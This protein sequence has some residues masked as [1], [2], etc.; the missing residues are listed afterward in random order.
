MSWKDNL[1]IV[2]VEPR[3]P[4]NIGAAARAM[5]NFGFTRLALVAP[6]EVAF[7]EARSAVGAAAVL[8]DACVA[9]SL[10]AAIADCSLVVG[11]A[12]PEG[13]VFRQPRRRL[14]E[15]ARRLRAH[16]E[17]EPAGI[18]FGSE[19]FGLS[20]EHLS[21][22]H[23]VLRIPTE[24]RCPSMNLGQ[25]VAVCCYELARTRRAPARSA[26]P[27]RASAS[28]L[29]RIAA[30]LNAVL[31]TSGYMN[32]KTRRSQL[33]KIRRLVARLELAPGDAVVLEGMLR[34]VAWKLGR[35]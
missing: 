12:S 1:R 23:W 7:R 3:N 25:A 9:D 6:Y 34:Q 31:E 21:H 35:G 5:L 26:P 22:C 4:L 30:R 15:A 18:L 19:K 29:E 2:L 33:L 24:P 8:Q 27:A 13:R 11:T 17:G 16:L 14:P 32:P 28:Q 20:N 10:A